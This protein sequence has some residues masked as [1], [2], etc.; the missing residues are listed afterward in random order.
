MQQVVAT[1]AARMSNSNHA[2]RLQVRDG[3]YLGRRCLRIDPLSQEHVNK[4]VAAQWRR[5]CLAGK[6]KAPG[7]GG[8]FA[9]T[10]SGSMRAAFR[11]AKVYV[12]VGVIGQCA[13]VGTQG[14]DDFFF[15]RSVFGRSAV[16]VHGGA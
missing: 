12:Y 3:W 1:R 13:A 14:W 9:A 4:N 7:C 5:P 11:V 16:P 8:T 15:T 10:P 2:C 6:E